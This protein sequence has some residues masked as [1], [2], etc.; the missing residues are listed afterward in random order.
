V[1]TAIRLALVV[2]G[3]ALVVWGAL[4]LALVI[5]LRR[6]HR[7]VDVMEA[8]RL[9]P[10]VAR[11]LRRLVG[12]RSLPW[13]LRVEVA[14]LWIYLAL[15]IDLV[16]DFIPVIGFADDVLVA[17]L[18]L[19]SVARRSGAGALERNWSGTHAGLEAVRKVCGL[20]AG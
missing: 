17:V 16:P 6:H 14:A 13:P 7:R 12:D 4:V 8:L 3:T 11:L 10:D 5:V 9:L 20:R 19:R 1:E 18:V 15:P 2:G